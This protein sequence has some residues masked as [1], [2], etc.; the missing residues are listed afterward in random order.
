M[1]GRAIWKG[2]I[3]FGN[4]DVPVKLHTAVREE[5]VHFH[6][7]HKPDRIRLRQEMVCEYEKVPVPAEDQIRGFEVEEGKYI[8]VDPSELEVATP[9]ESRMIEV[10]EF[11]KADRINPKISILSGSMYFSR[12]K[13]ST[14]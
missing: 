13:I 3:H 5:R 6:L 10:H 8:P 4:I 9:E 2:Y 1:A 14:S 12:I 11:V 7:L